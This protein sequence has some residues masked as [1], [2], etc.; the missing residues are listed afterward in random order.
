M[1]QTSVLDSPAVGFAGMLVDSSESD[2]ASYVNEEASAEI[3]FGVMVQQGTLDTDALLVAVQTDIPIGV[4]VHSHAYAKD[5]ELGTTGLK[6][7]VTL[8]I[9]KRGVIWVTAVDAVTPADDVRYTEA[10]GGFLTTAAGGVT[11]SCAE[12]ARFLTTAGAGELVQ[13]EIDM[14]GRGAR[15]SD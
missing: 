6:P 1:P 5:D 8:G 14:T 12:F 4:V 11:V 15:T 9:L 13:L 2:V 10:G 7:N 3:P